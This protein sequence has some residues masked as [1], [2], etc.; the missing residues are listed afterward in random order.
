ML[1]TIWP[2]LDTGTLLATARHVCSSDG[3]A[4]HERVGDCEKFASNEPSARYA[5]ASDTVGRTRTLDS[6][7]RAAS[8]SSK[9]IAAAEFSAISRASALGSSDLIARNRARSRIKRPAR[10]AKSA[11]ALTASAIA[12]SLRWSGRAANHWITTRHLARSEPVPEAAS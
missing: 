11:V 3:T 8:G 7:C 6:I 5:H 1:P 9:T 12:M 10:A 2:L 4:G